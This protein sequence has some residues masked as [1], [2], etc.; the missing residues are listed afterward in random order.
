VSTQIEL[1]K[2]AVSVEDEVR[3]LDGVRMMA[4]VPNPNI[5]KVLEVAPPGDLIKTGV[6]GAKP[7]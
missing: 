2:G 5:I 1:K 4:G 3:V 6:F 7:R